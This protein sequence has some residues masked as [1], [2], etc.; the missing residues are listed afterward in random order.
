MTEHRRGRR[1]SGRIAA[2][3]PSTIATARS[4]AVVREREVP[5]SG[6]RT[7]TDDL[8]AAGTHQVRI[9]S[10]SMMLLTRLVAHQ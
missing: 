3:D 7:R 9:G 6:R 4:V 10:G 8:I 1:S 2:G 5:R